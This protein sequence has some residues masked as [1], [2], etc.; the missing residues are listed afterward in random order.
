[1]NIQYI[2]L[3]LLATLFVG[4]TALFTSCA[5]DL[6]VGTQF[7]KE[8]YNGV[9]E[10]NAYLRDGKSNKVSNIVELYGETYQT[11]V[12]LGL[13][14]APVTE[15]SARVKIDAAYLAAY[16][17]VHG[18]E[19]ELYPENLISFANEGKLVVNAAAKSAEV[20]MAIQAGEA[21]QEDKNLC[22]PRGH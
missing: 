6:D 2:K 11:S 12:K 16:N 4:G 13:S 19:F 7:D 17:K 3:G 22:H 21:L 18:T 20:N 14:K 8:M 10:N 1:M 5:D 15:T 9:Y